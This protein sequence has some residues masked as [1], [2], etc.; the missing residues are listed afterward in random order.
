MPCTVAINGVIGLA[1]TVEISRNGTIRCDPEVHRACLSIR[2]IQTPPS[3]ISI[4]GDIIAAVTAEVSWNGTVTAGSEL[5]CTGS[6]IRA[7][8]PVPG[9]VTENRDVSPAVPINIGRR[10]TIGR[11]A[12]LHRG[13][14]RGGSVDVPC[15]I[16]RPEHRHVSTPVAVEVEP[17]A[18]RL[19]DRLNLDLC[20]EPVKNRIARTVH[21]LDEIHRRQI[22]KALVC[23]ACYINISRVVS[24]NLHAFALNEKSRANKRR[25]GRV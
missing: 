25:P 16:R 11:N 24:R 10:Y 7:S 19:N 5:N 18:E 23:H 22:G 1:I 3:A 14:T 20:N 4:H 13:G 12:E 2:E 15:P 17:C 21:R 6:A 9:S 8:Q